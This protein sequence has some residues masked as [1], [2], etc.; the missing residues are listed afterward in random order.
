MDIEEAKD[1]LLNVVADEVVGTYCIEIQK[2]TD[3]AKNCENDDCFIIRAIETLLK[4]LELKDKV[5]DEM[6]KIIDNS[7]RNIGAVN[8]LIEK[9]I[10]TKLINPEDEA[11]DCYLDMYNNGCKEHIKEYFINKVKLQSSKQSQ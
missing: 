6:A 9:R 2:K 10:C 1:I 5:I 7:Y 11:S 8:T 4:E 3:C